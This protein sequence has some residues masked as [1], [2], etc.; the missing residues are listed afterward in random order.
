MSDKV[1]PVQVAVRCRP[2]IPREQVEACQICVQFIPGEP[3]IILGKDKSFTYDN[4]FHPDISQR[5]VY[6]KTVSKLVQGV[7]K[8]MTSFGVLTLS[9]H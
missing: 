5:V 1:I 4:V 2:L 3:Q 6:D 9:V 7:F 8:G